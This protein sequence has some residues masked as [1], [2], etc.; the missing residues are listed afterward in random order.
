M[1]AESKNPERL[2]SQQPSL[3]KD[4]IDSITC[5]L[6]IPIAQ[7]KSISIPAGSS[8]ESSSTLAEAGFAAQ[9]DSRATLCLSVYPIPSKATQHQAETLMCVFC[10]KL[11]MQPSKKPQRSYSFLK[12]KK[13]RTPWA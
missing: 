3:E 7:D 4:V 6:D 11:S 5:S 12:E 10:A 2:E 9:S 8:E 1:E 13:T